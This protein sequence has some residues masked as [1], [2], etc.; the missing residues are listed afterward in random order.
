MNLIGFIIFALVAYLLTGC[1]SGTSQEGPDEQP[2]DTPSAQPMGNPS[3]TF[4]LENEYVAITL[5]RTNGAI[6]QVVDIKS[7]LRLIKEPTRDLPPW[8]LNFFRFGSGEAHIVEDWISFSVHESAMEEGGSRAELTWQLDESVEIK[9]T[10]ELP[11][12][13]SDV[14]FY[15]QVMN[16]SDR[17]IQQLEYPI[18]R[19]I[20]RLVESPVEDN[21]LLHP[22]AGGLLFIDPISYFPL[23]TWPTHG[24][25][26]TPYPEGV[27]TFAQFMAY[28]ARDVGGF[29]FASHDPYSTAK[30]V[31]FYW[32]RDIDGMEMLFGHKSWDM[33]P[34]NDLILDYPIAL[35][36]LAEG[37][38]YAAAEH[39]RQWATGSGD[40][41]PDWT[42]A[43]RLEDRVARG[44]AAKWLVEEVGFCTFGMPSSFDVSPW[45]QAFHEI[46]DTPVFHVL[47]HDWPQWGGA[48][49]ERM[50][51]L[52]AM[53]TEAGLKPFHDFSLNELWFPHVAVPENQLGTLEG[54]RQFFQTI[55]AQWTT[56]SS[57]RWAE[58]FDEY[59]CCGPWFP[60]GKEEVDWFPTRF[61]PGNLEAIRER[62]DYF[63]PFFFD[64]FAY[65]HDHDT[66]GL[67]RGMAAGWQSPL[68]IIQEAFSRIWMDPTTEY[69]QT[70]HAERDRQIVAESGADGLYYDISAGAGPRWSD[71]NDHG[72]P[73]G[74][75][76]WLWE[77]YAELYRLSKEAASAERG[78]YV[79]QGT[80]MGVE[81][82]IGF[83]DFNQWRAG[84]LVQGDI[85]LMPYMEL[86]KQ[87][88]AIK[89]PLFSFI[90]H[91]FGP[92]MLDGWAKL[93]PEFGDIFYL[94]AGQIALQQG[95]LVE[96]NYEYSPLELFPGME[97]PTYQLYYHSAI[98]EDTTP[99]VVDPAKTAYL[100]EI[101][102][103]RTNFAT[104]YLAYGEAMKPVQINAEIPII[105]LTWNHYNSIG[106]RRDEGV[107]PAPAVIQQVWNYRDDKLGLLFTNIA[108]D[109]NLSIEISLTTAEYGLM[110]ETYEIWRIT[111][112]SREQIGTWRSSEDL[113]LQI[114]LP[115]RRIILYELVPID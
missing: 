106:G 77:G 65:G 75:G 83:I 100:R 97:A 99:Y 1:A 90:Y 70:F 52:D 24:L 17:I 36:A 45:I 80:E 28:Y 21:L 88:M 2:E 82:L 44:D 59:N 93:A 81:N 14:F 5:N 87:G 40:G 26:Y 74:Y 54:N 47:G 113:I 108:A 85:E 61:H 30:D 86:V 92:V 9:S 95:G 84:G 35:G 69:W 4:A 34:G 105:E 18:V 68:E 62:G 78:T 98:Y 6:L 76:R 51:R 29:Y 38:W 58:I 10:I 50:Q 39:Y 22:V 60:L 115:S 110:A 57:T 20:E 71:R 55:G 12:T 67:N 33:H 27:G 41:H 64:F 112:D 111:S 15:V 19:G 3:D 91:E 31:D 79:P 104:D 48:S 56:L 66:Y 107:F 13:S 37:S 114:E 25:R 43:G 63:A 46:A 23:Y 72:H 42:A 8:R 53:F 89:L 49:V 32:P 102:L 94:I 101:A 96:L 11:D 103:A 73:M 109:R 7:G 16:G